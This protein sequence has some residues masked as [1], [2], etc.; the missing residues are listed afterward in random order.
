MHTFQSGLNERTTALGITDLR[1][2]HNWTLEA[3]KG[4]G[5]TIEEESFWQIEVPQLAC[6]HPFLMHSLLAISCRHLARQSTDRRVHYPTIAA[7]YQNTALPAYRSIINDLERSRTEQ[8]GYA[9]VAFAKLVTIYAVLSPPSADYQHSE[10]SRVVAH[11][12]E[13]FSLLRGA[14]EVLAAFRDRLEGCPVT[15]RARAVVSD[16]ELSL[17]P[18]DAHLAILN[19]LISSDLGASPSGADDTS[20]ASLNA[21]YLLRRC[22][23]MLF[24]ASKPV[25][26]MRTLHIWV[27]SISNTYLEALS[28]LRPKALVV[29][30]HWCIMLKR[31][32][33]VWYLQGAAENIMPVIASVLNEEWRA[34]IAWPLQVVY[35]QG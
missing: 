18:E 5:A 34:R 1:L 11:L 10:A 33:T 15:F 26:I 2:L 32:E 17:N 14:T 29:L 31:A 13:S 7:E 27:E 23:A 9:M 4:F 30:A 20:Q 16:I 21:L 6:T 35:N 28:E 25:S 3:Y 22:F 19:P 8:K 12:I 24:L